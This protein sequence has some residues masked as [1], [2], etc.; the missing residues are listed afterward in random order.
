MRR[1]ENPFALLVRMQIGAATVESRMELLK[2][3]KMDLPYDPAIPLMGIYPKK[4]ETLIW[5]NICASMLTAALFVIAKIWKQ[6]QC[7]SVGKWIK[8]LWCIYSMECYWAI[9]KKDILTFCDSGD[10]PGEYYAKWRKPVRERQVPYDFTWKWTKWRQTYE[11]RE[12][13]NSF[14]RGGIWG[15]GEWQT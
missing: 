14:P 15:L 1:K 11:Y 4:P 6:T 12:Q 5:K 3:L 2:K 13:T 7:P 8:K 10:G 9:K